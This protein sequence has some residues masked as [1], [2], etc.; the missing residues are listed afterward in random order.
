MPLIRSNQVAPARQ[1]MVVAAGNVPLSTTDEKLFPALNEAERKCKSPYMIR[2]FKIRSCLFKCCG[3]EGAGSRKSIC[4]W[5]C[6]GRTIRVASECCS[7]LT[8]CVRGIFTLGYC[9]YNDCKE[10]AEDR[11]R[12]KGRVAPS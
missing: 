12:L 6:K 5:A 8:T 7:S 1:F 10:C 11:N 4:S 3:T 2:V 9:C